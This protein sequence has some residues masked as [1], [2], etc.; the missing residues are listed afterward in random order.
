MEKDVKQI[1]H[2]LKEAEG[3]FRRI[4][5]NLKDMV[6]ITS[7]DGKFI[8]VNQAG[9]QMLGYR[10][11]EEL[12]QIRASDTYFNPEE[13][14]KFQNEIAKEGFV[15]DLEVK[16]KRKDGTPLEVLITASVRRDEEDQII[17]YEGIVKDVSTR[18]R[19]EEELHQR[20]KEL[21]TLYELSFIINQTL[22][23]D[24]VLPM[25]L[26]RV[27][28]LTGF[29]M[30]AIYLVS[31]DREWLE[32]KYHRKYPSHLEEAVKR[33]KWGEGVA[34]LVVDKKEVVIFSIDQYPSPRILPNLIEE[35]VKTLVGI[36]LL[37]KK[38]AIGAICL[39]SRSDRLIRQN[40]IRLIESLGNQIGMALENARLFSKVTKAKSEWEETFDA[41]TDLI[42]VRDRDYR[43]IRANKTAFK[44][45]GL[46]PEQI[47]GK[48]CFEVFY[49]NNRPCEGCHVSKALEMKRP[50]SG[51]RKSRYLNGIFRYHV[52]PIYDETGEMVGM[53]N[54]SR[55]ITEEKRLEMEKEVVNNINKILASSLNV[56]EVIKAVHS[57]LKKVINS[58]RM[59]IT[60]L[61]EKGEGF[62]YF[63]LEKD[64]EA[65]EFSGG[66]IYPK[67]GTPFAQAVDTGQPVIIQDTENSDSWVNQKLRKEGIRSSLVY[68]LEYKGKVFGTLNFGSRE[69]NNFSDQHINFLRSIVPGLAIAI[70]NALLFEETIK[71]LN[72]LTILYEVMK[73]SV[74]SSNLDQL[75][76]EVTNSLKNFFRFDALGILLVD[77]NTMRLI[78][79]PASYN[80][81]SI[82]NIEKLGL[83]VGRGITG[84]VAEKGEPL[85]VNNV[86]EDP[87]YICGDEMTH[88]EMCAP[89]KMGQ[90][91]IG[92][93]DAQSRRLN[94]FSEDDFRLL[95]IVGGLLATIIENTRLQEGIKHS[96]EKY[97][98]VVEGAHDGICVIGLDNRL[99]YVNQ[100]MEEIFGYP[101]KNLIGMDF[102]D[103]ITEESRRFI[104]ERTIRRQR[105]EKLSPLF[106]LNA[107]RKDGEVRNIEINAKVLK[108]QEAEINYIVFVRDITE[109]KRLEQQL[110]QGE[111]LRALGEMASGVAH[112]FNNAL[113]AI[114]GNA[115]LMLLTAKEEELRESLRTIE[116]VAK[117]AAHTVKR[118][119]EFTRK[120]SH[121][122]LYR[123]D[124]NQII[125]DAI[126]ITK[127]KWKDE[128]QAKGIS[129]EIISSLQEIPTVGGNA[130]DLREVITNMIFNSIE[131]MP[132]GGKIEIRTFHQKK[133]V[134]IQVSD[135]GV[136]MEEEVKKKIFEPFFTTKPFSNTGLGLSMS[137]GIIKRFGGE[138]EVES[139]V[140]QGTT[141]T[142]ILP[143]QLEGVE[144]EVSS[145]TIPRGREARILVIEDEE[146]VSRA[147]S[148]IL[149]QFNH[150]VM[151][152]N[153]GEEGIRLFKENKF[154]IVLTDLGMPGLSGWEVCRAI[155]SLSPQTP[156][157]MITGWGAQ[158]SEEEIEENKLD[159]LISKPFD[160]NQILRLISEKMASKEAQLMA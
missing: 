89:L 137:Y 80:E 72:E 122:E 51:E 90:R 127:P 62:R 101:E 124:I 115:Q 75:L 36:P 23:L 68:P 146:Q 77:E 14:E 119:Q 103:L 104:E 6:Y 153:N 18:K 59:T 61:D 20:T 44:R 39:T 92:V 41:V 151:V 5:E 100:R 83:S 63:A 1:K 102:R 54:L 136:G 16:L 160:F 8:D 125:R 50:V 107:I 43:I 24:Q 26:E 112:D 17:G 143:I 35:K 76:R 118:L 73:V 105:G 30:G 140:G 37:A 141:F 93:I 123:V 113:A 111:K 149:S 117:D 99:R 58:E 3:K 70:Q 98:K 147:L 130:S 4:F 74:S 128:A 129:I 97:R 142:I 150:Q 109:K 84:W 34:G 132:E 106:E 49:Q 2:T 27:L 157:G 154:D 120:R 148:K 95:N 60:L 79:H 78:P 71:R 155:K 32:L 67:E 96:E 88:S 158:L 13:R 31:D 139:K 29:E 12:M 22:N 156:V 47:I 7:V 10:D 11:K 9:V 108:A 53:V 145:V 138:I 55:E 134:Y 116:K 48:R 135:T 40:E 25:A 45:Y 81:L 114:L 94:A 33:L 66:V 152:A 57:E 121:Q 87:R 82:K 86:S 46:K 110:L 159:F 15:K 21:E 56:R 91:V 131:A 144:E 38:E 19:M 69:P 65:K 52:F 133:K 64:Y 85:L 28:A 42:T 126:E